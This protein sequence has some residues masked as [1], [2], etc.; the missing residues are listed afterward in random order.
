MSAENSISSAKEALQGV[1]EGCR[2]DLPLFGGSLWS[3][4]PGEL[5]W[6]WRG[7]GQCAP[8]QQELRALRTRAKVLKL[9]RNGWARAKLI[10][11][12]DFLLSSSFPGPHDN[13]QFCVLSFKNCSTWCSNLGFQITFSTKRRQGCLGNAPGTKERVT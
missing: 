8:M 2:A 3:A 10:G 1:V 4:V 11:F 9:E 12:S 5:V 7:A 6:R 13:M